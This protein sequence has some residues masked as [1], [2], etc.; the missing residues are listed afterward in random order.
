MADRLAHRYELVVDVLEL[1][2]DRADGE[3]HVGAGIAV[4]NGVDVEL[5]DGVLV[6][7]E[8]FAVADEYG[9]EVAHA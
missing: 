6:G 1:G 3:R 9:A 5:V 2:D 4:G 8:R 7:R